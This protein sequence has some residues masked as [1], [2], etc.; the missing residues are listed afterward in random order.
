ME[1]ESCEIVEDG[2]GGQL[3][4]MIAQAKAHFVQSDILESA[5]DE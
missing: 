4:R 5:S 1:G 3:G 2:G